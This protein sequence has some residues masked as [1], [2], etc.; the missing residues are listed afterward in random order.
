MFVTPCAVT[1]LGIVRHS[2]NPVQMAWIQNHRSLGT[3]L[4]AVATNSIQTADP[5]TEGESSDVE[6]ELCSQDGS[7]DITFSEHWVNGEG[8]DS[9]DLYLSE[10]ASDESTD[11]E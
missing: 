8:S 11:H 2:L 10:A 9:D 6:S 7:V 3:S 5:A 4:T 1:M